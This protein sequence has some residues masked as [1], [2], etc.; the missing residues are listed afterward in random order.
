M[1]TLNFIESHLVVDMK[2]SI[3]ILKKNVSFRRK[4]KKKVPH[5][6]IFY[7]YMVNNKPKTRVF[8]AVAR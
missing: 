3:R 8:S 5:E 6:T 7:V 2:S 4:Y 1:E